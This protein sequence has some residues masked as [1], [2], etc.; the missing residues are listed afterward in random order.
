M[1]PAIEG[2]VPTHAIS[3][4]ATMRTIRTVALAALALMIGSFAVAGAESLAI[5]RATFV[6]AKVE[7]FGQF[8]PRPN[9]VF[10]L[11]EDVRLYVEPTGFVAVERTGAS[12]IDT[13]ADI[14]VTAADGRVV[15]DRK[16]LM[17]LKH[18]NPQTLRNMFV[19]FSVKV[20]AAGMYVVSFRLN[21][22]LTGRSLDYSLPFQVEAPERV[23]AQP[24]SP[25]P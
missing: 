9:A 7:K 18:S 23:A 11:G 16:N 15:V 17:S 21:D 5:A 20:P 13:T 1:I 10:K 8:E 22:N 3:M 2:D 25:V 4:E 24:D 12:Q 6:T 14:K 19:N